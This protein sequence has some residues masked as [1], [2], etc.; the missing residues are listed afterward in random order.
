MRAK[1]VLLPTLP[2]AIAVV[3]VAT[4]TTAWATVTSIVMTPLTPDPPIL[5]REYTLAPNDDTDIDTSEWFR[6]RAFGDCFVPGGVISNSQDY[7][8]FSQI[9]GTYSYV[10]TNTYMSP[11]PELPAPPKTTKPRT[12]TIAKDDNFVITYGY[13]LLVS[14]PGSVVMTGILQTGPRQ[15]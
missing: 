14:N 12:I 2:R 11:G 9:P 13:K 8:A 3:L 4:A 5:G 7:T 10:L 15:R 6:S 1:A